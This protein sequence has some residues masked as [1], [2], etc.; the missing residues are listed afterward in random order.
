MHEAGMARTKQSAWYTMRAFQV[1][2]E[3]A[4]FAGLGISL[5]GI[6]TASAVRFATRP[7]Q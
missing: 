5:N 4:A 6:F 1:S 7:S 2:E 3:M